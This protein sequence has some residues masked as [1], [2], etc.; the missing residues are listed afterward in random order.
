ME[1]EL[2]RGFIGRYQRGTDAIIVPYHNQ[3]NNVENGVIRFIEFVR[4]LNYDDGTMR[5]EF[6]HPTKSRWLKSALLTYCD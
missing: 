6:N 5:W 2:R 3:S 4:S 1:N